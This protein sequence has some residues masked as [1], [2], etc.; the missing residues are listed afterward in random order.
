MPAE[1][2]SRQLQCS[3]ECKDRPL[4]AFGKASREDVP[5]VNF[6]LFFCPVRCGS[7]NPSTAEVKERERTLMK[8]FSRS[9][10]RP[11]RLE[12]CAS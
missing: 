6:R 12:R 7:E 2:G 10:L 4:S 8:I 1:Q 11:K 5:N 3:L 9:V